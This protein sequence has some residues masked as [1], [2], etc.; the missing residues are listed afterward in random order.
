MNHFPLRSKATRRLEIAD[1]SAETPDLSRLKP[2]VLIVGI[3]GELI[4]KAFW[5]S[6]CGPVLE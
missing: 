4:F 1:Y 5:N 3:L 2:R 6:G